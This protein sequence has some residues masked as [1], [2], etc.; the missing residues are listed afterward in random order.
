MNLDTLWSTL[1]DAH[2]WAII[3]GAAALGALGA[4][5]HPP[6]TVADPPP[7][8]EELAR[9]IRSRAWDLL[10]GAV[11]A[12][13]ILYVTDPRT[14]VALIGGSL[15]AGFAANIVL[16]SLQARLVAAL[17]VATASERAR[18]AGQRVDVAERDARTS[19]ARMA[20]T[21][22]DLDELLAAM[23]TGQDARQRASAMRARL[24]VDE[25]SA[26]GVDPVARTFPVAPESRR[27][28]GAPVPDR[29]AR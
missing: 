17:A 23:D 22:R 14:G 2:L 27:G 3:A 24:A 26:G 18:I 8:G 4:A 21:R 13:A 11:A 12:I 9:G 20:Q 1:I 16:S 10:A 25:R 28:A 15:V 29:E 7:A 6:V 5:L 19:A